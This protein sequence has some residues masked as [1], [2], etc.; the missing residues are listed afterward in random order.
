MGTLVRTVPAIWKGTLHYRGFQL[1]LLCSF[2]KGQSK[3]RRISISYQ[4]LRELKW[5]ASV[6][7][8]ANR[9]SLWP[10]PIPTL[11]I[12]TDACLYAGGAKTDCGSHFQ[13]TWLEQEQRKHI[14][15]LELRAA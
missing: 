10:P 11:Q 5:W 13:Y 2:K 4:L 14:N 1:A 12:W 8:T 6:G 3:L 9:I 15:W 7:M